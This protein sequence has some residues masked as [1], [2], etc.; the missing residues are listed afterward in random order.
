MAEPSPLL[1]SQENDVFLAVRASGL[2]PSTFKWEMKKSEAD[3][4][5]LVSVLIHKPTEYWFM[6][7]MGDDGHLCTYSPGED[8][9]F[10]GEYPGTWPNQMA[11]VR[12]WLG[13]LK[14]EAEAPDLWAMLGEENALSAAASPEPYDEN[15]PFT[16]VERKRVEATLSEIRS[17]LTA[18]HSFSSEKL[19]QIDSRLAYLE[20]A[21]ERLGR[22][23]WLNVAFSVVTNIILTV[24]LPPDAARNIFNAA[25]AL[26]SWVAGGSPILPTAL[27]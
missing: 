14:R 22:K 6:F 13:Y 12:N 23:D 4:S 15:T 25:G 11:Y 9:L 26:L 27:H 2:D 19:E 8:T 17:L 24:A 1:K 10:G 20:A 3:R 16:S 21:S 7:D 5:N 18:S